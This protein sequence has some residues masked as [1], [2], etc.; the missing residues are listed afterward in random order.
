[1]IHEKVRNG[2]MAWETIRNKSSQPCSAT[3]AAATTGAGVAST[4]LGG[5]FVSSFL[6]TSAVAG[7]ESA[8]G[9]SRGATGVG[10]SI[11]G[12]ASSTLTGWLTSFGFDLKNSPTRADKRRPILTGDLAALSSFSSFLSSSFL[13]SSGVVSGTGASGSAGAGVSV[14]LT[15]SAGTGAA[16]TTGSGAGVSSGLASAGVGSSAGTAGSS[17]AGAGACSHKVRSAHQDEGKCGNRQTSSFFLSFL[18]TFS[19]T[20]FSALGLSPPRSLEMKDGLLGL[21]SFLAGVSA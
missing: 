17:V 14:S 11:F 16:S 1:M 20:F 13:G 18:V 5:S 7:V 10:S 8:A 21:S 2:G 19:F 15:G 9:F 4:I 12:G 6:G 3:Q